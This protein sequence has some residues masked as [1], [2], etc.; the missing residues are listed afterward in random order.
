MSWAA[1][2]WHRS[3]MANP[4]KMQRRLTDVYTFAEVRALATVRG[5][6]GNPQVRVITLI[7][8]SKKRSAAAAVG[9]TGAGTTGGCDGC[10]ISPAVSGTSCWTWRFGA[11]RAGIAVT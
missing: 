3:A 6:F 10:A 4:S 11:C 5:V 1:G 9:S 7:R 2:I 8:R